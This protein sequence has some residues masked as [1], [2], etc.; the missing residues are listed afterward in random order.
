MNVDNSKVKHDEIN[1]LDTDISFL[2]NISVAKSEVS[3]NF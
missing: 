2:S 1:S 3:Y